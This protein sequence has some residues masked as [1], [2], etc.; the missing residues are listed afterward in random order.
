[1][2]DPRCENCWHFVAWRRGAD[3]ITD[4]SAQG[5]CTAPRPA[6]GPAPNREVRKWDGKGCRMWEES[7][8][9]RDISEDHDARREKPHDH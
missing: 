3:Y 8:R 4:Y 2:D 5:V 1:M 6:I 7:G 9:P